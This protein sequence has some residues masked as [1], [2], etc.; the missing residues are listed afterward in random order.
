MNKLEK[1]RKYHEAHRPMCFAREHDMKAFCKLCPH[2]QDCK[3]AFWD[4]IA[5]DG[6]NPEPIERSLDD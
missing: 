2:Y 5:S 1:L 6:I 3:K 4:K